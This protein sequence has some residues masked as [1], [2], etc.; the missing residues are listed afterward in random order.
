MIY[1]FLFFFGFVRDSLEQGANRE[2]LWRASC[3]VSWAE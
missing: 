2:T 3:V 1:S